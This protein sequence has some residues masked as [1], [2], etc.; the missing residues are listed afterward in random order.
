MAA[1]IPAN[2][3]LD[4]LPCNLGRSGPILCTNGLEFLFGN[5]WMSLA[6]TKPSMF[7]LISSPN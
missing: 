4:A 5:R 2:R 1:G 6:E 3:A 7:N